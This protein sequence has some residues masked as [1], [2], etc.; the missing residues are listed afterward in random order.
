MTD[1]KLL[2]ATLLIVFGTINYA[3]ALPANISGSL[4]ISSSKT[5]VESADSVTS[6]SERINQSYTLYWMKRFSSMLQIQSS[7][8]YS[9]FDYPQNGAIFDQT[10]KRPAVSVYFKQSN[11]SI[12]G[13]YQQRRILTDF[14]NNNNTSENFNL[15]YKSNYDK[16]PIFSLS[17]DN[18]SIYNSD[19][20]SLRDFSSNRYI[21]AANYDWK[22]HEFYGNISYNKSTNN[23][24][25][26]S[27]D[28]LNSS[29]R[30]YQ[31]TQSKD[32]KVN[33]SS[34]YTLLMYRN[35]EKRSDT[36]VA[37]YPVFVSEGLYAYD[38]SPELAE[39]DSLSQLIDN[40]YDIP[41]SPEINIG[42]NNTGQNIGAETMLGSDISGFYL[43]TDTISDDQMTFD[44]YTSTNN[45]D[46]TLQTAGYIADF[47]PV[48]QRY[49]IFIPATRSKYFKLV[50]ISVNS[51]SDVKITELEL[52][53]D[54]G[55]EDRAVTRASHL[56][57][58]SS[59]Y[60]WNDKSITSVDLSYSNRSSTSDNRPQ[61]TYLTLS[62]RYKP[63]E[64]ALH[65][66]RIQT[67]YQHVGS[68]IPNL[69]THFLTYSFLYEPIPTIE[70]L[71]SASNGHNYVGSKKNS[72]TR[73]AFFRTYGKLL[74]VLNVNLEIGYNWS[75]QLDI[76]RKYN[77]WRTSFSSDGNL[78][79]RTNFKFAY[80]V[81]T[82]GNTDE[83]GRTVRSNMNM[84]LNNRLSGKIFWRM[85]YRI[86]YD[87]E[88]YKNALSSLS[89]NMTSKLSTG[90]SISYTNR[91][92]LIETYQYSTF[93]N[94]RLKNRATLSVNYSFGDLTDA[95]G[96][97]TTSLLISFRTSL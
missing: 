93:V 69:R 12:Y 89:W 46:W 96:S 8:N 14:V 65:V 45:L 58:L 97:K 34:N 73:N 19:D 60:R 11:M 15:S 83:E 29:F 81:T 56:I 95:G 92:N 42:A 86:N 30:W 70:W 1:I 49:E 38:I 61:N 85:E 32:R 51:F 47:D 21:A 27:S 88:T 68:E 18:N 75:S 67:N 16:W 37:L 78:T 22:N 91:E 5:T 17:Y 10:I 55:N 33:F 76:D 90:A 6:E 26:I 20:R 57:D 2:L 50:N 52:L 36:A 74:P 71:F 87:N 77:S 7:Y 28:N 24:T 64:K 35:K 23:T 62:Q 44:V 59:S 13:T 31:M 43:Y 41:V 4:D 72:E 40:N 66:V 80:T 25:E 48:L 53:S 39:L 82:T 54:T 3:A 9:I 63:S 94:M 84:N 79:R